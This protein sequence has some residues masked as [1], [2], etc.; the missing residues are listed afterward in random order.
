M[1]PLLP[2]WSYY[3]HL[4][5]NW[6]PKAHC[7][8]KKDMSTKRMLHMSK[9][10]CRKSGNRASYV[11]TTPNVWTMFTAMPVSDPKK[12]AFV[13]LALSFCMVSPYL[14]WALKYCYLANTDDIAPE[15]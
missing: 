1:F 13:A 15:H 14:W 10:V 8:L 7:E 12:A 3:A 9:T 11:A 5:V 2:G 4:Q 6:Y